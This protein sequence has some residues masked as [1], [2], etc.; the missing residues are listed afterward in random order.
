MPVATGLQSRNLPVKGLKIYKV[1]THH[2]TITQ[3]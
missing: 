3:Q 1:H 2:F